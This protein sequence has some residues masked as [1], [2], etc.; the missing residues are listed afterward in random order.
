MFAI[1][2]AVLLIGYCWAFGHLS[3][4]PASAVLVTD[5]LG[6]A[7]RWIGVTSPAVAW[8]L[9]GILG[10]G[11][12]G[13]F[14]GLR[15]A[16]RRVTG[17]HL[18]R[19]ATVVGAALL[20]AGSQVPAHAVPG[21]RSSIAAPTSRP[22]SRSMYVAS[23]HA[24]VRAWPGAAAA[25]IGLLPGRSR[26]DVLRATEDG[27]WWYV[28]ARRGSRVIAGWVR[29]SSLS[30]VVPAVTPAVVAAAR[31]ESVG[32]PPRA[33]DAARGAG[34][35]DTLAGEITLVPG[36]PASRDTPSRAADRVRPTLPADSA[37][38]EARSASRDERARSAGAVVQSSDSSDA[39][40][41]AEVRGQLATARAAAGGGDY[42]AALRAL[43]G[44][45][46]SVAIAG[47]KY[48][49]ANWLA[50]L[51][52]EASG[53]RS[54]VRASCLAAAAAASGRGEAGPRCE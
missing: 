17:R 1:F 19:A 12:L 9:L 40:V 49:E 5:S 26:L 21:E 2:L 32:P 22:M 31:S 23:E 39:A 30:D 3:L 29:R 50:G 18:G 27:Q 34:H 8:L 10:G 54:A 51:R 33:T 48:R 41:V 28:Q 36:T 46:E 43:A 47:A 16:G 37:R 35:P 24:S 13:V 14:V 20:V 44:A 11:M 38:S 6:T 4:L 42:A 45:D 25:V 7:F 53:V 15:R 52:R